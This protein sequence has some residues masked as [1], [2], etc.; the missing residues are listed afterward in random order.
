MTKAYSLTQAGIVGTI[1]YTQILFAVIIGTLLGDQLPDLWS[2]IGM[3][4]IVVAGLL[5][6]IPKRTTAA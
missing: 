6:T 1:T 2:W 5:V 4:L 3:G